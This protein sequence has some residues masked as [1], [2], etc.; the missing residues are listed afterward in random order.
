MA[1]FETVNFDGGPEIKATFN[2]TFTIPYE[3]VF[4]TY[5]LF[6]KRQNA[7]LN[8]GEDE[9]H[10]RVLAAA[11]AFDTSKPH[12]LIQGEISF[13]NSFGFLNAD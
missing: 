13:V 5:F 7:P 10:N 2:E 3:G 12:L 8:T 1:V 6:G 9:S 11:K 4:S